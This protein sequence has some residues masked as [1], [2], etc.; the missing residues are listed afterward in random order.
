M[1]QLLCSMLSFA[2]SFFNLVPLL[3]TQLDTSRMSAHFRARWYFNRYP[4]HYSL[5][6]AF[7]NIPN[8]HHHSLRFT[9]WISPVVIWGFQ[10]PLHRV[11]EVRCLLSTEEFEQCGRIKQP[12]HSFPMPFGSSVKAISACLCWRSLY[13]DSL[14]FTIL[15][16]WRLPDLMAVRRISTSRSYSRV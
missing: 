9:F 10:V 6:F 5:A 12:L 3:F 4:N 11:C 16:I 1:H 15:T 13:T 2:N 14:N 7:S 8:S